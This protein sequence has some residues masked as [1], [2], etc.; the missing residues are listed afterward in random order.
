LVEKVTRR[1]KQVRVGEARAVGARSLIS[2][3]KGADE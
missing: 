3:Q 1:G 2:K